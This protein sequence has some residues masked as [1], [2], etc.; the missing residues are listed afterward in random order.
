MKNLNQ[1]ENNYYKMGKNKKQAD[2][3]KGKNGFE[4]S[5]DD[6]VGETKTT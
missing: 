3:S 6:M 4:L 2:F 1:L 5:L